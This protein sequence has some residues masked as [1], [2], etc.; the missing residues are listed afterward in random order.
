[1]NNS[2][3]WVKKRWKAKKRMK[4]NENVKAEKAINL[5]QHLYWVWLRS[6]LSSVKECV[7]FYAVVEC[8]IFKRIYEI[9]CYYYVVSLSF[10]IFFFSSSKWIP[11]TF[12]MCTNVILCDNFIEFKFYS[13]SFHCHGH[14]DTISTSDS[15][16]HM[17]S[18]DGQSNTIR[19]STE[20]HDNQWVFLTAVLCSPFFSFFFRMWNKISTWNWFKPWL[21]QWRW[22]AIVFV[23]ILSIQNERFAR[24]CVQYTPIQYNPQ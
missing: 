16:W 24:L 13:S 11:L 14:P 22:N 9:I 15:M 3:K 12:I 18:Y 8:Q 19:P 10:S 2:L 21:R 6:R 20:I 5:S 1:M 23:A 4:R 7:E 17:R